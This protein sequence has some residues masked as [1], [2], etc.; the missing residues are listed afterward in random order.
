MENKT[1]YGTCY[2][3]DGNATARYLFYAEVKAGVQNVDDNYTPLTVALKVCRNPEYPY[4]AS[5]YNL[6]DEV[7]VKLSIDGSEVFST[8]TADIDTRNARVWTFTTQTKNV[9]HEADGSK[10][11][12]I[13]ASFSGADVSSLNKGTLSGSVELETIPRASVIT[14]AAD[15]TLGKKCN[16]KWTPASADF[17]YV[18]EFSLGNWEHTTGIIHPK[19]TSA[20]TY[21]GYVIP[22]GV[23]EQI[24]NSDEG[25]MAV[26]LYTYS[27]PERKT[28]VGNSGS[29]NFTVTVPDI[30]ATWP[31]VAMTLAPV[32]DLD[33]AFTGLYIQGKT[34]VQAVLSA[35][36]EYGA[37]I[38]SYSMDAEGITYDAEDSYTSDYLSQPGS[39]TI[40]GYA[41]DSRGIAGSAEKTIGV[42]GYS[43]PQILAASGESNV[44]AARCDANGNLDDSGTYLKIK[45]KRSYNP[46]TADGEQKNFCKIQYRY[47]VS[48]G[49]YSTWDTILA[50]D[51][52]E[53]DEITTGALLGGALAADTTYVV[54]V[55]AIDDIGEYSITTVTI[56]TE[57]VYMHRTKNA[58]GLGKY[59]EEAEL[60]DVAWN[61]QFRGEVRIGDA[62][63]T[64]KE[65]ILSVVNGGE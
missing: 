30:D 44:V 37:A 14:S 51:A 34:K 6:T 28:P 59:V 50:S 35:T 15:T 22:L 31:K 23:A 5:A 39:T 55:Q 27:D 60:L 8:T 13:S 18:L 1:I 47:K 20:Y 64:L 38:K 54:Q 48:G 17:Y 12:A 62:G 24:V 4:A 9:T 41:K 58:M 16:I 11:V 57:T 32:S 29:A 46:V 19:Q 63:M 45:A 40:Y 61:A 53:S 43:K 2:D 49:T 26:K 52:L 56:P 33:D 42:I 36:G 3:N 10:T 25:T 21:T 65:Y 7:S